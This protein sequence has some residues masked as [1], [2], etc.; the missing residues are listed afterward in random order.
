M[1]CHIAAAKY[2][3][4]LRA[5]LTIALVLTACQSAAAQ[6]AAEYAGATSASS[7]TVVRTNSMSVP[8]PAK[9]TPGAAKSDHLTVPSGPPP[10]VANRN[11]LEQRAGNGAGKLF[12]RS[13]PSGA[14]VSIDG[15]FVGKTPMLLILAPGK[16]QVEVRGERLESGR[17]T[18][19]LLPR[20]T[21]EVAIRMAIRY[22]TA[23]SVR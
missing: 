6:S 7:A 16:Y 13:T 20:E 2:P 4:L 9:G 3:A 18:V 10:E 11:A 23:V 1:D 19:A 14:Q 15:A 5:I 8:A 22:P 21:R 12:V 17:Q